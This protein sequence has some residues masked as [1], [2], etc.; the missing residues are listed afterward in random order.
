MIPPSKAADRDSCR[1]A[2]GAGAMMHSDDCQARSVGR[3]E[4]FR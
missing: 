4:P 3:S 1:F 2:D